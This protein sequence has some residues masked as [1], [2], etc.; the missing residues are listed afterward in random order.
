ARNR[1]KEEGSHEARGDFTDPLTRATRLAF[2]DPDFD[3]RPAFRRQRARSPETRTNQ[4]PWRRGYQPRLHK[5]HEGSRISS[6]EA[7][8]IGPKRSLREASRANPPRPSGS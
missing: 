8:S 7:W 1:T 3:P 5:E 6:A 4:R 2:G